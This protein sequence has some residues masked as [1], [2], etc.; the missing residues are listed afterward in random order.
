MKNSRRAF[1]KK[2]VAASSLVAAGRALP[3]WSAASYRRIIGANE[4]FRVSIMGVNSRGAALG[5]TF[6]N[7][8]NCDLIHVCDVDSR[9]LAS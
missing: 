9:A 5:A 2:T 7:Q 4:L 6:A 1:I 3:G 8:P